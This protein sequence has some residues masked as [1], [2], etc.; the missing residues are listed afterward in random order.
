MSVSIIPSPASRCKRLY[1]E[2][3]SYEGGQLDAR[4]KRLRLHRGSPVHARC[5]STQQAVNAIAALQ[6]L[7]PGMDEKVCMTSFS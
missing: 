2:E 7:F 3:V 1:E 4:Q 6:A 5:G